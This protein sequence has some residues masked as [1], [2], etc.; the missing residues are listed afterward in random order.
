[1]EIYAVENYSKQMTYI[2][3]TTGK[4]GDTSAGRDENGYMDV[5]CEATR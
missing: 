3:L 4:W 1:M 5:W 2:T